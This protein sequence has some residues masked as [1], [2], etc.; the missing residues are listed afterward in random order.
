MIK[1]IRGNTSPAPQSFHRTVNGGYGAN[2]GLGGQG[3]AA[4]FNAPITGTVCGGITVTN[5][6]SGGG[7]NAGEVAGVQR[8]ISRVFIVLKFV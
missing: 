8:L 1:I 5:P 4:G 2:G 6:I 3:G 7:C